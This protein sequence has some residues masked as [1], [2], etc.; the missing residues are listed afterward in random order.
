MDLIGE[1]FHI[2]C[3]AHVVCQGYFGT[4]VPPA[5][6]KADVVSCPSLWHMHVMWQCGLT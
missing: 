5:R 1:D 2:I 4:C 6:S 3:T